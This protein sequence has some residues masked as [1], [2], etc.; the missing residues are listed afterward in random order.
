MNGLAAA[1]AW[2][3]EEKIGDGPTPGETTKSN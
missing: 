2:G 1:D 3:V